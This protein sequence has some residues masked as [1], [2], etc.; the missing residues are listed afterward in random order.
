LRFEHR[1]YTVGKAPNDAT[2]KHENSSVKYTHGQRV[3]ERRKREGFPI[4]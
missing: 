4:R 1:H 2:Y 3:Y